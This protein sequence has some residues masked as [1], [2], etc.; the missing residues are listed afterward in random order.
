MFNSELMALMAGATIEEETGDMKVND[1]T[2][3]V[4]AHF[5]PFFQFFGF[6]GSS[7]PSHV[8]YMVSMAQ[9]WTGLTY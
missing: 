8:T 6:S 7:S 2:I 4:A 1:D 9:I 5:F 3:K